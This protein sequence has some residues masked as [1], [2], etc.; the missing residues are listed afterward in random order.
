MQHVITT[1]KTVIFQ[2]VYS[3]NAE[4]LVQDADYLTV[5]AAKGLSKCE[6]LSF[7]ST[8]AIIPNGIFRN[9]ILNYMESNLHFI[10]FLITL[11]WQLQVYDYH[12]NA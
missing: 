2:C 12:K 9:E 11:V 7:T 8:A 6:Q 5:T 10:N 3:S 1:K 4:T